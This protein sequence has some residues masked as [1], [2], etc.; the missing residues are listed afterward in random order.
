VPQFRYVVYR[1]EGD[2]WIT[3]YPLDE[4]YQALLR[5]KTGAT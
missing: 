1:D 5:Q 2:G 3:F 4:R